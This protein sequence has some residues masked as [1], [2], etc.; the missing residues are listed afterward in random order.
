MTNCEACLKTFVH[1]IRRISQLAGNDLVAL[2]LVVFLVCC[3]GACS[4]GQSTLVDLVPS[5]SC[6]VILIDWPTV[7]ADRDLRRAFNGDQLESALQQIGIDG[8]SV[9]SIAVFSAINSHDKAGM[10][11]RASLNKQNQLAALKSR[12]WRE[13]VADGHK[14]L[15]KGNDYVTVPQANTLFAGTREAA[16]AVFEALDDRR[17]S[18]SSLA[19][20]KKISEG[21]SSRTNP[22]RAFLV[23]P[24]GTLDMADAALE[25]T[26]FALSLFEM[27]GVGALLKQMNIA[28]GFGLSLGRGADQMFPV[29]M[30]VLM[31][32]EKA[33][34]FISGSLNLVKSFSGVAAPN[35][36]DEQAMQSLRDLSV[37][38]RGEVL[39]LK[40]KVPKA[41]LLPPNGR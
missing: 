23:I 14:L 29:E 13:E 12:G 40:L 2:P 5:D 9:K 37:N 7:R 24:Q 36:R 33:A 34:A 10:L 21:M 18:F 19:T 3:A 22:I 6:A 32:D 15:V 30:C 20:Y 28:S 25:G 39:S 27:G 35:M 1:I 41:A 8:G 11:L 4:G 17:Q 16:L 31:R 26:S 38:R